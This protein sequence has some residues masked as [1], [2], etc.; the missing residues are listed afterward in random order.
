MVFKNKF[1]G[2]NFIFFLLSSVMPGFVWGQEAPLIVISNPNFKKIVIGIPKFVAKDE[3]NAAFSA[4]IKFGSDRLSYLLKY[5]GFFNV[6]SESAYADQLPQLRNYMGEQDKVKILQQLNNFKSLGLEI[7]VMADFKKEAKGP[8]IDLQTFDLASGKLILAKRFIGTKK[9]WLDDALRVYANQLVLLLTGKPGIFT[10]KLAFVGRLTKESPKQIYICDFDGSNVRAVTKLKKPI[11]SP[12]WSPDGRYIVFTSFERG[13]PDLYRLDMVTSNITRIASDKGLNSGGNFS[14]NGKLLTYTGSVKGDADL[15]IKKTS[16][17]ASARK[18]FISGDGLDSE[19]KFSPDGS[20]LAYV[21]GRFGNPHIFVANLQWNGDD[22]VK[23]IMDK[24]I[25]YAGWYNA[26]PAW[27]PDSKKLAFSGYDKDIDRFDIFLVNPDG[28]SLERLTINAGDNET[29]SWSPNGHLIT[30]SSN[31]LEKHKGKGRHQL[32][33][34]KRDGSE[35]RMLMT[36]LYE[37]RQ[38][39]WGPNL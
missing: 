14:P 9:D 23:A 27:S 17:Y 26:S 29:P 6:A 34:M 10:S 5:S 11:L 15:Y 19:P 2:L 16:S 3:E 31:R 21:S 12:A 35:Q 39:N 22:D 30:F 13:N 33:V 32:Y 36:N 37:A 38:P 28:A 4:D 8:A 18:L 24:R 7:L 1:L 25:T 20:M